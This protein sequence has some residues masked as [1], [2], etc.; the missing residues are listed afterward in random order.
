MKQVYSQTGVSPLRRRSASA[1]LP[2]EKT[3]ADKSQAAAAR[4]A[5]PSEEMWQTVPARRPVREL[6][7]NL[8]VSAALVLCAVTLRAGAIPS[9]QG[10]VD[11]VLTALTGDDLLNDRLGKLSFV[12]AMF[13]ESVLV[14]GGESEGLIALPV[15]GGSLT[16]A[17]SRAEPYTTW[18]AEDSQVCAAISGEV[19][20]VYHGMEE[21]LLVQIRADGGLCCV[22]GNLAQ[23]SVQT[24]DWVVRGQPIGTLMEGKPLAFEVRQNGVSIDPVTLLPGIT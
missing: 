22:H 11:A 20:G 17:W 16:H 12:S 4:E 5:D 19:T 9:L 3:Q 21:E 24:G 18:T 2:T 6:M 14:F 7:K 8:A 1:V 15:M 23:A 10:P 13:P